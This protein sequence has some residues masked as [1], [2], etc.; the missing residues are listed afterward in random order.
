MVRAIRQTK[1]HGLLGW[2]KVYGPHVRRVQSVS[3]RTAA[4]PHIQRKDRAT[5]TEQQFD[6]SH[7]L[8]L[9]ERCR[10]A[11]VMQPSVRRCSS[12]RLADHTPSPLR[13][14]PGL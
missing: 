14:E 11:T 9:S 1:S 10:W 13:R 6:L 3:A 5:R 12:M 2:M 4:L 7:C 8:T